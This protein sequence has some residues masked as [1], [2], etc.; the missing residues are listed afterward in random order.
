VKRIALALSALALAAGIS[1]CSS[2]PKMIP[3][4]DYTCPAMAKSITSDKAQVASLEGP[5]GKESA[6]VKATLL[7]TSKQVLAD[8]QNLYRKYCS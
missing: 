1:A 5:G 3:G 2:A 7:S 6:S 8:Q 4:T